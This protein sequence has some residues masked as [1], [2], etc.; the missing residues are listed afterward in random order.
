MKN[1]KFPY[2]IHVILG[3]IWCFIGVALHSEIELVI[4]IA[5]GIVMIIVGLLNR[6]AK[7]GSDITTE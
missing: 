1:I 6:K 3:I 2:Q 7:I 4:W 5:G